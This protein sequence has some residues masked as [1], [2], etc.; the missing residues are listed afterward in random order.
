MASEYKRTAVVK[1]W[2]DQHAKGKTPSD[3]YMNTKEQEPRERKIDY[4][5]TPV[6][7]ELPRSDGEG[8]R[9]LE[10]LVRLDLQFRGLLL[11]FGRDILQT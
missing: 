3:Q 7:L 9:T 10:R 2:P 8:L 4:R 6:D 11:V 1:S 5:N